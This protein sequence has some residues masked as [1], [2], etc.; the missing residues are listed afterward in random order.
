MTASELKQSLGYSKSMKKAANK[1]SMFRNLAA[2]NISEADVAALPKS[3]D[4]RNKGVVSPVK[5]QGHCGSCWAFASVAA[6]ESAAAIATGH[7]KTLSTQQ[8]VSCVENAY[9]C[10]G[11]GGCN[12]AVSEIAFNYVQLFGL[13]SEYKYSYNSYQGDSLTCEFNPATQPIEVTINGY[14]KLPEN[15]YNALLHA[16]ATV[17]PI[18]IS[19]DASQF[20][21]YESGVFTGCSDSENIDI[22]HAVTLVGYGTDEVEGDYWLVR[23]SWGTRYGENGYI[24]VKR[25]SVPVCKKDTTPLDGNGCV[26]FATTQKVCGQCGILSDSAYPY[27][28][29]VVG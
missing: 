4:W 27:D 23:N 9:Q 2:S 16:I 17:G 19:V 25:D 22:N 14:V 10:G 8:L 20:H 11:Q 6:I 5:D 24:R 13:T 29:N 3:V 28:V 15:D 21:E 18:V 12:G 1:N 7:L 26:G